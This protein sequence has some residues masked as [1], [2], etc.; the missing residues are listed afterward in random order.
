MGKDVVLGWEREGLG[1]AAFVLGRV[2]FRGV[3]VEVGV[4]LQ[5][6]GLLVDQVRDLVLQNQTGE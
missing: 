6:L 5:T 4:A 1:L 3:R 2:R